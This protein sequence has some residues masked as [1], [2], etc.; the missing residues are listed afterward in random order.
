MNGENYLTTACFINNESTSLKRSKYL[1]HRFTGPVLDKWAGYLVS[2]HSNEISKEYGKCYLQVKERKKERK[3]NE[4][5][6]LCWE[7]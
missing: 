5:L 4:R 3:K 7:D 1:E 2:K 6:K